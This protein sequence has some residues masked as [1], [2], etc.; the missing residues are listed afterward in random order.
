MKEKNGAARDSPDWVLSSSLAAGAFLVSYLFIDIALP[1]SAAISSLFFASGAVL[2]R[3]KKAEILEKAADLASSLADGRKKLLEIE[4]HGKLIKNRAVNAKVDA[5]CVTVRKILA[6]IKRD[7]ED[8]KIARQFLSYYLDATINILDK[9]VKLTSQNVTDA[10]ISNSL[11]RV[12]SMLDTIGAAFE[13]QLARLLNNDVMD[14]DTELSLLEKTIQMEG[15]G[16]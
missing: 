12:E 15:L 2:F 4:D 6:E 5:L 9:Y 13:K 3:R 14:L 10:G 1:F 8:L 11:K 16:E 7:P